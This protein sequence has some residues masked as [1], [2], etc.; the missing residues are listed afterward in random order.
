MESGLFMSSLDVPLT[1]I[2]SKKA[3]QVL[4]TFCR[5]QIG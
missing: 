2:P 5:Q 1:L 3:S 4:L